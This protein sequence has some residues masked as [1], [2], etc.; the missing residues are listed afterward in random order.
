M[1]NAY[2]HAV[3]EST[4]ACTGAQCHAHTFLQGTGDGHR[5]LA[6]SHEVL[7]V[8]HHDTFKGCMKLTNTFQLWH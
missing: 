4:A 7:H 6:R 5:Q 2:P 8:R 1:Q 3:A